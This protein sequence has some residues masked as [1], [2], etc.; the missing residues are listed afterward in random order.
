MAPRRSQATIKVLNF[1]VSYLA[2]VRICDECTG[3]GDAEDSEEEEPLRD[4][5]V[6]Q[7]KDFDGTL[8]NCLLIC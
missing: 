2:M 7:L 6:E 4:F 1:G 5:T 8:C 3:S